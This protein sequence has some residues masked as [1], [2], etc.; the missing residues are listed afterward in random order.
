M[1][2]DV[3]VEKAWTRA[4]LSK[5]VKNAA[6][7]VD[8]ENKADKS[9]ILLGVDGN[10]ADRVEVHEMTFKDGVMHMNEIP[11]LHVPAGKVI[12]LEPGGY[13]IM[14]LGL[15]KPLYEGQQFELTFKFKNAGEVPVTVN[16]LEPYNKKNRRE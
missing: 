2:A 12:H 3:I 8:I 6:A 1:G 11:E 10:V 13:H 16:T 9:D 15:K 4:S 14:L 7:Y 5:A